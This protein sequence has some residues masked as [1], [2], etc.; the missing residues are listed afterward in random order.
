MERLIFHFFRIFDIL[1]LFHVYDLH[2]FFACMKPHLDD[3]ACFLPFDSHSHRGF[4]GHL[5]GVLDRFEA[6]IEIHGRLS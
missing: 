5:D 3:I 4:E 2:F 6:A 1:H